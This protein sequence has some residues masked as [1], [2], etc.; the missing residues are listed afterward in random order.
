MSARSQYFFHIETFPPRDRK[1]ALK[2][3]TPVV[4][5]GKS[6]KKLR[7]RAAPQEDQ[8]C[9]LTWIHKISQTLSH[10]PGCIHKLDQG[11]QNIYSRELLG[12]AS[13]RE[14]ASNP[15]ET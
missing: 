4:E 9:E 6:W 2:P 10:Q 12:L 1:E 5:W 11:P 15:R 7:R 8:Q 14:D 3:G 13:V